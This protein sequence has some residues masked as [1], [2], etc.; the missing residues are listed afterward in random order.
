MAMT[1]GRPR[2]RYTVGRRA[3]FV[4][5]MRRHLPGELFERLYFREVMRRV[6]GRSRSVLSSR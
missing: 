4:M 1:A 3:S 5:S 6:T 2:L